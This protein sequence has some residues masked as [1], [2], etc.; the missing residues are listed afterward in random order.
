M[1]FDPVA[2]ERLLDEC[3]RLQ[4]Q[5]QQRGEALQL[6]GQD[7]PWLPQEQLLPAAPQ[8]LKQHL[9]AMLKAIVDAAR[10][11]GGL[12]VAVDGMPLDILPIVAAGR[13]SSLDAAGLPRIVRNIRAGQA[14]DWRLAQAVLCFFRVFLERPALL[15]DDIGVREPARQ[16]SSRLLDMTLE[17]ARALLPQSAMDG[18]LA[19]SDEVSGHAWLM[20][21]YEIEYRDLQ[22]AMD[23]RGVPRLSMERITR[24]CYLKLT[25]LEWPL[26]TRKTYE[27]CEWS[28]YQAP[29]LTLRHFDA[30]GRCLKSWDVALNKALDEA[31]GFVRIE[32]AAG[33]PADLQALLG[34]LSRARA[35]EHGLLQAEWHERLVMNLAGR[36]TIVC[37]R[38]VASLKIGIDPAALRDFVCSVGDSPGLVGGDGQWQLERALLPREVLE[39][40]MRWRGLRPEDALL[41]SP[42]GELLADLSQRIPLRR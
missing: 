12:E 16:L 14:V 8:F 40:R 39:V 3:V 20:V 5:R 42:S 28:R 34:E 25:D 10:P 1:A 2:F 24:Y 19:K 27:W 37:L 7:L 41:M 17:Q 35:G 6:R 29:R 36:D 26:R 30:R 32:M 11:A 15:M 4:L 33:Q 9:L 22:L 23:A 38:P 31:G 18:L 13:H 21:D